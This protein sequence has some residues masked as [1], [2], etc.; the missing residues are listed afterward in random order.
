RVNVLTGALDLL[1]KH[2]EAYAR[3]N[4][5]KAVVALSERFAADSTTKQERFEI[6]AAISV[7]LTAFAR[8][9][10]HAAARLQDKFQKLVEDVMQG[11]TLSLNE[12][13]SLAQGSLESDTAQSAALASK[14][15]ESGVP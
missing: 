15:L 11:Y 14:V 7:L 12:R 10:P 5:T 13:L 1:W 6:R 2:D 8:H 3:V 9:D 4:F